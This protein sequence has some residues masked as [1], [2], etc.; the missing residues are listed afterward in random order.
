MMCRIGSWYNGVVTG[1]DRETE[2][3]VIMKTIKTKIVA[4]I[5]AAGR[6]KNKQQGSSTRKSSYSQGIYDMEGS[7]I[8]APDI[9]YEYLVKE[10]CSHGVDLIRLNLSHVRKEDIAEVFSEIKEAIL[11][12]EEENTGRRVAL[13]ADL[14]GPKIRFHFDREMHFKIGAEFTVHFDRQAAGDSEAAVYIDDKPL[15]AAM[16]DFEVGADSRY[17]LK[18]VEKEKSSGLYKRFMEEIQR[19]IKSGD[20]VMVLVGDGDVA[21]EVDPGKFDVDG[22]TVPCKVVTV[23]KNGIIGNKGFTLKGVHMEIPSFT[24]EDREKLAELLDAEYKMNPENPVIAFIALSF[25]QSADDVLRVKEYIEN[26][27]SEVTGLAGRAAPLRIPSIITK[28]ETRLGWEERERILDAADGI[29]VARGDLG[30][31]LEIEEVPKIQKELI[32]LCNKRGKPVITATEMLKSMTDSIEPTRAEGTDVF[33]AIL[34][35]SDAVMTSD[36][37]AAG[38]YPFHAIGKMRKI[39]YQAERY[40]EM[41]GIVNEDIRREAHLQRYQEFLKDDYDRIEAGYR[42]IKDTHGLIVDQIAACSEECAGLEWR[43]KFYQDKLRIA[44][45]QPTT[46]RVTQATCTMSEAEEVKYII[47]A[48]TSGRTVRMISRLRPRLMIIGAAH[49]M[50]NTRKLTL[51]YGV[52]P[53]CTGVVPDE[54]GTEGLFEICRKLILADPG[55]EPPRDRDMV[56]FTA[57]TPLGKP[58]TT[59]LIKMR[60]L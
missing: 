54:E 33:N 53:I 38:R 20:R 18:K 56:I 45:E 55:L 3:E 8:A 21:M 1:Q 51:S 57:G 39:A 32:R 60:K 31:Q 24:A 40:F 4:T 5:G 28:I 52:K 7:K 47:A 6:R 41:E 22:V 26:K 15:K 13:L 25:T 29:M 36:E 12:W 35:G 44:G 59:N 58:G 37:T 50:V 43:R 16:L 48:S 10:F 19:C 30:L 11:A 9:G 46:N 14:P 49:D 42:R 2:Q 17:L 27:L 34:D 23:K